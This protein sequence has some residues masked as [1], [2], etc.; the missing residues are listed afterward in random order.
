LVKDKLFPNAPAWS[1]LTKFSFPK[2][3]IAREGERMDAK[4]KAY[5]LPLWKKTLGSLTLS[6]HKKLL[7][8]WAP[9][10]SPIRN[11]EAKVLALRGVLPTLSKGKAASF[12]KVT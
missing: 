3:V 7:F 9:A 12:A 1:P 8:P 10:W 11:V 2:L 5:S 6:N 4:P